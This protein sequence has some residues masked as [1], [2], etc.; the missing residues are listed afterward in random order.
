[1]SK[2]ND[3]LPLK[4]RPL[5]NISRAVLSSL[6]LTCLGAAAPAFADTFDVAANITNGPYAGTDVLTGTVTI[7]PTT[8][9]GSAIDLTLSGFA[10]FTGI[11]GG[12]CSSPNCVFVFNNGFAD[13]GYLD[14]GSTVGYTGGALITGLSPVTSSSYIDLNSVAYAVSG[15][16]TPAQT[17]QT[18]ATPEPSSFMLLGTGLLGFAG[19]VRRKLTA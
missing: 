13:F 4:E 11:L 12:T 18:T 9:V 7:D 10:D 5:R 1:M 19:M 6:L 14:L 17:S 15:T 2:S 8:G 16:V 3:L